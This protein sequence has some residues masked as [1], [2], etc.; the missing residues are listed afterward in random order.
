MCPQVTD[1]PTSLFVCWILN[2]TSAHEGHYCQ[3]YDSVDKPYD[4]RP[5]TQAAVYSF[6]VDAVLCH[7]QD[8][9]AS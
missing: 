8:K 1:R 7:A 3:E 2:G 9:P 5:T 6:G 4:Y